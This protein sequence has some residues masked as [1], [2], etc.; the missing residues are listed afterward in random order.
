M[1]ED[2]EVL[3]GLTTPC[4]FFP[5]PRRDLLFALGI[6]KSLREDSKEKEQKR[7]EDTQSEFGQ[8]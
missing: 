3:A 4:F 8:E 7:A 6:L 1:E 5:L 2:A